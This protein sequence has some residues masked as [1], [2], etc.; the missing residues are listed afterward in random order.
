[1]TLRLA[2]HLPDPDRQTHQRLAKRLPN[3]C[4]IDDW[5]EADAVATHD[6]DV[7]AQAVARGK[8]L[9]LHPPAFEA[10]ADLAPVCAD[11]NICLM[12]AHEWRFA[13]SILAVRSALVAGR[14][15]QPGL[16]RIHRWIDA[17]GDA[18]SA[19]I[20]CLPE[21]DLVNWMFGAPPTSVFAI[22]H[23]SENPHF[24]QIHLG[25]RKGG[26][27]LIDIARGL[28]EGDPYDSF[29]LIGSTG[30]AYADDHRNRQLLFTGG[31]AAAPRVGQGSTPALGQLK[32]FIDA[33]RS[34]SAP[35]VG[36]SD[37]I[38]AMR[39]AE[40]VRSAADNRTAHAV[41]FG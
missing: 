34:G 27:A 29:S 3:L 24:I 35:A 40:A 4:V 5:T 10:A 37:T 30:A 8:H 28:P 25:F 7:A 9:L 15:G 33:I 36:V 41:D 26:M 12:P 39:V 14:L 2:F 11:R 19:A 23:S 16:I 13:P 6:A 21:I 32:A 38:A 1:M 22:R 20:D 17:R 18:G 31:P